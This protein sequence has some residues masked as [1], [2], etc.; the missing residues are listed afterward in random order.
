M[1]H[2]LYLIVLL[3]V[4]S[5]VLN[6]N[7]IAYSQS[8]VLISKWGSSGSSN[9]LFNYPSDIGIGANGS[10][11]Y[12]TDSKNNRIQV[13]QKDGPFIMSWGLKGNLDDQMN[14]PSGI[15]VDP[16][17]KIVYVVDTGNNRI[18]KFDSNGNFISSWGSQ[19]SGNGQFKAPLG[20]A[21]DPYG[22]IYVTDIENNNIQS[23]ASNFNIPSPNSP[24]LDLASTSAETINHDGI[25]NNE[26]SMSDLPQNLV[27]T[28]ESGSDNYLSLRA[29]V[30]DGKIK[31]FDSEG[32]YE[33]DNFELE[34]WYVPVTFQFT[35][36]SELGL[37]NIKNILIGQ[38]KSYKTPEDILQKSSYWKQLPLNVEIVLPLQHKGYN[39]IIIE[40]Q[41]TDGVSGIYSG[42]FNMDTF[43]GK[44]LAFDQIKDEIRQGSDYK[45]KKNTNFEPDPN[46]AF[47]QLAELISC[48]ELRGH[49]FSKC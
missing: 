9:G 20:I 39:F 10:I 11:F 2:K 24:S 3:S 23:F 36:N 38:I 14:M 30:A 26:I 19:G 7:L 13:F 27:L 40:V 17:N 6:M 25:T 32:D 29:L 49:G 21:D 15:T 43:G 48:K 18:Q 1:R 33:L 45:I 35:E 31:E 5:V 8:N 41:F 42:A 46:N 22:T 37:V 34:D 47:W 44:S 12:V 4:S 16:V 28:D